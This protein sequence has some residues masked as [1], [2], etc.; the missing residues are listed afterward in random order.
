MF[1]SLNNFHL[2]S[3]NSN[4]EAHIFSVLINPII[5]VSVCWVEYFRRFSHL[6]T[7]SWSEVDLW[8]KHLFRNT[9]IGFG[10]HLTHKSNGMDLNEKKKSQ[11]E[12]HHFSVWV[13]N[14]VKGFPFVW[15]NVQLKKKLCIGNVPQKMKE[16]KSKKGGAIAYGDK[17]VNIWY[18][19]TNGYCQPQ[20][21]SLYSVKT[22]YGL[23]FSSSLFLSSSA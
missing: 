23:P 16:E 9:E 2:K 13:F 18:I 15:I 10:K 12:N 8:E 14:I 21:K 22:F 6:I 1:F 20:Q 5:I 11:T 17:S 4:S 3:L 19:C 7:N